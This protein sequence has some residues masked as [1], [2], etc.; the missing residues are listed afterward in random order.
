[1]T[2]GNSADIQTDIVNTSSLNPPSAMSNRSLEGPCGRALDVG[3][4]VGGS[5]IGVS[6]VISD[7]QRV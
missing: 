3:N 2:S 1:M 7:N 6:S 4:S 5:A